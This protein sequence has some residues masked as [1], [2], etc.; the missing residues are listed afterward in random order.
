MNTLRHV[1]TELAF[2]LMHLPMKGQWRS[3]FARMGG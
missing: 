3:F 2:A 1:K